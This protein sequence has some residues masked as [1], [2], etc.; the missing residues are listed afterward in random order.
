[1]L[2]SRRLE[3]GAWH[4]SRFSLFQPQQQGQHQSENQIGSIHKLRQNNGFE[5][6]H[7]VSSKAELKEEHHL[8]MLWTV[9]TATP[10]L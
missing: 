5:Y 6:V 9:S 7:K 10:L 1:M 2:V 8:G 3:S 4:A